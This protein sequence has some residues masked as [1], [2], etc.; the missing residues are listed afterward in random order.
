MR[1]IQFLPLALGCRAG[2]NLLTDKPSWP[3]GHATSLK[4]SHNIYG[5][6]VIV[7]PRLHSQ[8]SRAIHNFAAYLPTTWRLHLVHGTRNSELAAVIA[9]RFENRLTLTNLGVPDLAPKDTAYNQ[10]LTS[11]QFW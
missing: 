9:A 6:A 1:L 2:L 8:L 3:I 5:V 7:E 11:P 4:E 10:L